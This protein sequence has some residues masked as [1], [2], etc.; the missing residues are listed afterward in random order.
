MPPAIAAPCPHAPLHAPRTYPTIP[1]MP[2]IPLPA[3]GGGGVAV[4]AGQSLGT[5]GF[6]VC[7]DGHLPSGRLQS[8]Q[9]HAQTREVAVCF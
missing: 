8:A 2:H 3:R 6:A 9:A 5:R 1:R 4:C 7:P